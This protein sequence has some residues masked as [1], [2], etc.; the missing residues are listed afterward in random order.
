M[1]KSTQK[2]QSILDI[3]LNRQLLKSSYWVATAIHRDTICNELMMSKATY[4]RYL[5]KLKL[6]KVLQ[7]TGEDNVFYV[8]P[9]NILN[10][11]KV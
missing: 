2:Q 1:N 8:V 6:K 7:A 9:T 5:E 10:H 3:I 11:E 4:Y